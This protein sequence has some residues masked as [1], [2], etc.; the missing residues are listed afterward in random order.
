MRA[1]DGNGEMALAGSCA[2]DED[3]IALLGKESARCQLAHQCLVDRRAVESEVADILGERQLGDGQLVLDRPRLLLGNLGL[4]QITD[5]ARRLVLTL[6]AGRHHLVV[7]GAHAIQ[8]E[9]PHQVED[10][11]AFHQLTLRKRS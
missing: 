7:G 3:S 9:R 11:G 2:T 10:L 6:D 5:N 1:G 8:L 4:E